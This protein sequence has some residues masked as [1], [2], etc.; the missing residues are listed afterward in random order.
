MLTAAIGVW[1]SQCNIYV[2]HIE[3]VGPA[4]TFVLVGKISV[5]GSVW[6]CA[7]GGGYLVY[8]LESGGGDMVLHF[9]LVGAC[10]G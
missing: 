3:V 8:G 9:C 10:C 7:S 2:Y 6:C 5:N 1:R 4:P